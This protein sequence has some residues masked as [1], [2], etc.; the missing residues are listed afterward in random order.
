MDPA[1][2]AKSQKAATLALVVLALLWGYSWVV[3]KIGIRYSTPFQF[4]AC[5]T[6]FGALSLLLVHLVLR[7]PA[8]LKRPVAT[9]ALGLLQTAGFLLFSTWGMVE[10][11]AGKTA[12]LSFTMPFWVLVL[13]WPLLGERIRGL[14]WVAVALALAGL[15]FI[16]EPWKKHGGIS[17]ELLAI[18]AG[19]CWAGGVILAKKMQAQE[20]MDLLSVTFWQMVFGTLPVAVVAFLVPG[21]PI[22]WTP[23]F[24]GTLVYNGALSTGF[25]WL[26]WLYILERLPAGTAGLNSLAI[27]VVALLSSAIQLHE[28]PSVEELIGMVFIA[29]ALLLLSWKTMRASFSAVANVRQ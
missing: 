3:S 27:P 22:R 26:I 15:V 13:A 8:R 29:A 1:H 7:R 25:G 18:L 19:L 6:A 11:G 24:W 20:P 28:V 9:C 23:E 14:Q 5:R 21:P 10:S 17:G 16:L 2:T 12:V 4:T